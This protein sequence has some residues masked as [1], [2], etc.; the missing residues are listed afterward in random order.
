MSRARIMLAGCLIALSALAIV[1]TTSSA[2]RPV[3]SKFTFHQDIEPLFQYYCGGCHTTGGIA[4]MSLLTYSEAFPWAES[5]KEQLLAI[6]MH[7]RNID[8]RYGAE[9]HSRQ[10]NPRQLDMIVDWASGGTPEGTPVPSNKNLQIQT[11][12]QLGTPD[13]TMPLDAGAGLSASEMDRTFVLELTPE[14]NE[15]RWLAA[16]DVRAGIPGIVHDVVLYVLP[17]KS[18][19]GSN[20]VPLVDLTSTQVLG[21]WLP[22]Q[23]INFGSREGAHFVPHD[24]RLGVQ[25]HYR[26]TWRDEGIELRDVS[27]LGLYFR[28]QEPPQRMQTLVLRGS[29]HSNSS[30]AAPV[31]I[32]EPVVEEIV[33]QS[34]FPV[35][36]ASGTRMEISIEEPDGRQIELVRVGEFDMGWP[37]QYDFAEPVYISPGSRLVVR[38]W[39]T[40]RGVEPADQ[41]ISVWVDYTI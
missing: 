7:P 35:M 39:F 23:I 6:S 38:G 2:H 40:G 9:N 13:I 29:G 1:T 3:T 36:S 34:V 26:K 21:T 41:H 15:D 17:E 16:F 25:I 12:W 14:L 28:K 27:E 20:P 37:A 30:K 31:L 10:M 24:A 33:L 5:I 22:G 11:E 18:N 19:G 32:S 4:P 8:E